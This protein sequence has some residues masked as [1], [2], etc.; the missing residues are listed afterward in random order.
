MEVNKYVN[1]SNNQ[2]ALPVLYIKIISTKHIGS[3]FDST[4]I[5]SRET[6]SASEEFK[7]QFYFS[8]IDKFRLNY[9]FQEQN[10]ILLR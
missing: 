7:M 2:L 8:V 10:I 6:P 3:G 1:T 5:G 9:R 4:S